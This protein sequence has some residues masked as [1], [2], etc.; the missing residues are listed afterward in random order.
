MTYF[1]RHIFFCLNQRDNK[2]ASCGDHNPQAAFEHCKKLVK[3]EQDPDD[4]G[5]KEPDAA[6]LGRNYGKGDQRGL[7]IP[8]YFVFLF[9]SDGHPSPTTDP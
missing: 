4:F 5:Q 9:R 1:K 7:C 3:G 2:E 8:P 6:W